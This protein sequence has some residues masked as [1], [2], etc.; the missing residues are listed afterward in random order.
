MYFHIKPLH[1]TDKCWIRVGSDDEDR[2][3]IASPIAAIA[4][5]RFTL[6]FNKKGVKDG[7][8]TL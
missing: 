4:E 1:F 8:K 3:R 6:L 7:Y 5:T 2:H